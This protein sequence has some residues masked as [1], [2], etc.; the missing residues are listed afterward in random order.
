MQMPD[1]IHINKSEPDTEMGEEI[2]FISN[3]V[4]LFS[5]VRIRF[6]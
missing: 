1:A 5:L 3:F 2:R 4:I 6:I